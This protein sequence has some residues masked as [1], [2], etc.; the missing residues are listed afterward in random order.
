MVFTLNSFK[1]GFSVIFGMCFL[2]NAHAQEFNIDVNI[3]I[4][5]TTISDAKVF[6]VLETQIE[7]FYNRTKW[8]NE[9]FKSHEK[10][11]GNIQITI[12]EE[13]QLGTYVTDLI[14]QT[15]RP[16]FGSNYETPILNYV[17]DGFIFNFIEGQPIQRS[18]NQFYDNLSST[19]TYYAYIMLGYDYDSFS[20]LGGDPYFSQA[21]GVMTALPN[22]MQTNDNGWKA[23]LNVG[24]NKYWII[25]NQ[26][27]PRIRTLR[28]VF[29]EYHIHNLDK[30]SEDADKYR[31]G[32]LSTLKLLENLIQS[33]PNSMS[34]QLFADAKRNEIIE[35]Y[36]AAPSDQKQK[37]YDLMTAIEPF[38]SNKYNVLK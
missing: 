27:D 20:N 2:L 15:S 36:K 29:Y 34:M 35:I 3:N 4:P 23:G 16:V 9:E 22:S 38:Q 21:M 14:I 18:D 5:I 32:L 25:T 24:R 11:K 6:S 28:Q 31:A 33:Y 13:P 17:E 12:R 26:M 7:E 19:L 30:M 1:K 8:T 10:I 37:I